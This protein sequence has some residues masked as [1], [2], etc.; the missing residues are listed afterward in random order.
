MLLKILDIAIPCW[1]L[2][3]GKLGVKSVF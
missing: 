1:T 2:M 3:V